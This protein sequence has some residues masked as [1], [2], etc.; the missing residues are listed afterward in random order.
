[1]AGAETIGSVIA[2]MRAG[3]KK[4]FSRDRFMLNYFSHELKSLAD[5]LWIV[6]HNVWG[7]MLLL[8][9]IINLR[10]GIPGPSSR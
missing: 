4:A 9:T 2:S 10:A 1:M 7:R 5:L 8:G 6:S 3:S